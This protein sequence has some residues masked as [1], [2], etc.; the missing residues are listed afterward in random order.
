MHEV[1]IALGMI[2][3]LKKIA[4]ENNAK[5]V[6][7]VKLKI[8]IMSG[9]VTDSLVFAF[10]AVK[11]EHPILYSAT[12]SIQEVPLVYEC[13]QCRESFE[14]DSIAFPSCPFCES[15]S[16]KLISGEEQHIENVELEV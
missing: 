15:H 3:E 4:R 10:D 16:L 14:T 5:K 13:N 9:I 6:T 12:I 2:E 8:G 1:S 11:L 7:C